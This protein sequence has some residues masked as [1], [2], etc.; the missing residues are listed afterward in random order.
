MSIEDINGY[1][2]VFRKVIE[3]EFGD[4][5]SIDSEIYKMYGISSIFDEFNV[6]II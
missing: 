4:P 1:R 3:S 2:S 5:N 6:F